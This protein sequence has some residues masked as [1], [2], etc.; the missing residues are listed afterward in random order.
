MSKTK[1]PK[2]KRMFDDGLERYVVGS[3]NNTFR[4]A[5]HMTLRIGGE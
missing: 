4:S 2:C 1:C 5:T 3:L